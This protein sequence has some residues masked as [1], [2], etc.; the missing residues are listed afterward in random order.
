M[1]ELDFGTLHVDSHRTVRVFL[2][3]VTEVTAKWRLNYVLFPKKSN[4]GYM[5]KTAWESENLEKTDDPD[6]FEF[7]VTEVMQSILIHGF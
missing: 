1:D 2:S 6:V 7:S 4:F 5:T 3:N